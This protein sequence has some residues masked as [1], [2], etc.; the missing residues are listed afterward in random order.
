MSSGPRGRRW[1]GGVALS[2]PCSSPAS[3]VCLCRQVG[4]QCSLPPVSPLASGQ[5]SFYF[6]CWPF[7][8]EV[9]RQLPNSAYEREAHFFGPAAYQYRCGTAVG[10]AKCPPHWGL[11][12][13][14]NPQYPHHANQ[15]AKYFRDGSLRPRWPSTGEARYSY[16][17][18][19]VLLVGFSVECQPTRSNTVWIWM[20]LR[21]R[22]DSRTFVP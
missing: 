12:L 5:V 6:R 17:R 11:V 15:Y 19:V 18:L 4:R 16:S 13:T 9:A 20:V 8:A 10:D 22:A 7:G 2:A 1:W 21:A 14:F 3:S